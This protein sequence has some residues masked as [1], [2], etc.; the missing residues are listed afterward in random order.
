MIKSTNDLG[1]LRTGIKRKIQK[2]VA[3]CIDSGWFIL[4]KNVELFEREF[5]AYIGSDHCITVANGTQALEIALKSVE[6]KEGDEV[7]TVAN[8]GY[9]GTGAIRACGGTPGYADIDPDDYT[10]DADSLESCI[11]KKT[12]AVI[13]THL[14]GKIG[15]VSRIVEICKNR[16]LRLIEDCAQAHGAVKH[17]KKAGSFG[18]LSCF[19]FYPTKN[20]GAMGDGGAIVTSNAAILKKSKQLRQ[21][22]WE[23]KY[24]VDLPGGTNSRLDE[25]Q[26]A[27]LRVK[28]HYLDEWNNARRKIARRYSNRISN[29]SIRKVP[30]NISDDFVAHLYVLQADDRDSLMGHLR[31]KGIPADI[32]YPVPDHRQKAAAGKYADL[33]LPKTEESCRKILTLPCFPEMTTAETDLVV[34]SINNWR[35]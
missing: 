6:V 11:G 24:F 29:R 1:R 10:M 22:G 28:L 7:I 35:A 20:L 9:Y 34:E 19:S 32:H 4:G 26:A 2:S 17:G 5:A 13:L 21:Y 27:V 14:Y 33:K 16:G 15:N 18:D 12:K 25:I 3:E 23:K 8:A 31:A 30:E